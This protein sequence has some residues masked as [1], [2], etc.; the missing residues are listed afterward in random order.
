MPQY[1]IAQVGSCCRTPSNVRRAIDEPV[2]ME[3]RDA[4]LELRLH[5][6]IAGGGEAQLAELLVL[7]AERTPAQRCSDPGDK[8]QT[9]R[10]H[11]HLRARTIAHDRRSGLLQNIDFAK[12]P[13]RARN[14]APSTS[15]SWDII[16]EIHICGAVRAE[17]PFRRFHAASSY[18]IPASTLG[19]STARSGPKALRSS[20]SRVSGTDESA[21]GKLSLQLRGHGPIPFR[22]CVLAGG[23]RS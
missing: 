6:G 21:I 10:L 20:S 18:L 4:A 16:P 9:L 12:L 23:G 19:I 13:L 1:A 5:L 8:Y 17:V 2:R 11:G 7:L 14:S 15:S 3:H 22:A